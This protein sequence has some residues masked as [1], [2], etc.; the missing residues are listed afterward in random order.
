MLGPLAHASRL[1]VRRALGAGRTVP[2]VVST[3][4]SRSFQHVPSTGIANRKY[5]PKSIDEMEVVFLGT[6]SGVPTL[7]RFQQSV[8]L[9]LAGNTWLFDCGEAAQH[10]MLY[11]DI[12]APT[13]TRIF[14]SH[15]HGD[16]IFGL[17]GLL[18]CIATKQT[19]PVQKEKVRKGS[20]LLPIVVVGPPGLR[21]FLR[22]S[23]SVS[24]SRQKDVKI[25]IHELHGMQAMRRQHNHQ[26]V[27]VDVPLQNEVAGEDIL[28]EEDGSWIIPPNPGDP[29]ASVRAVELEHTVPCVGYVVDEAPREGAVDAKKLLP[30]LKAQKVFMGEVKKIK[31]GI[32]LTLPD[33]TVL[34][35]SDFIGP[36]TQRK[37][38][39]LSDMSGPMGPEAAEH[40]RGADLL[41]HECTNACIRA[42]TMKVGGAGGAARAAAIVERTARE[43]GHSTP[44][45][46]GSF[47]DAAEAKHLVLTHFGARFS[48]DDGRWALGIMKELRALARSTYQGAVTSAVDLMKITVFPNGSTKVLPPFNMSKLSREELE[49]EGYGYSAYAPLQRRAI[50]AMYDQKQRGSRDGPAGR[51]G[52]PPARPE[53]GEAD[54]DAAPV[55]R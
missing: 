53:A 15:L 23:L 36:K 38:A 10:R 50:H 18:C 52:E 30:L 21:S 25:Q 47:A 12:T 43:K 42:D 31:A 33:G 9:R 3:I 13:V 35:P 37:I 40:A 11:T 19:D 34:D 41:I 49:E 17:P 8:A 29:P 27:Q 5:E 26:R 14:V 20:K 32:P 28:P 54:A 45:M 55:A 48:G 16:H 4:A 1:G 22:T 6:S 7:T 51:E 39:I 24:Y 44:Q 2:A 46:A